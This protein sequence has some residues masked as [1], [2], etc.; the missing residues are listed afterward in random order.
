MRINANIPSLLSFK[1]FEATQSKLTESVKRLTTGLRVRSAAADAAGLAISEKM[2]AIIRGTDQAI[3]NAQDGQSMLRVAEG[4]LGEIH[5]IIQRMRELSLQAANDTLIAEDRTYIQLEIDELTAQI[6]DIANNTQFNKKKILNGDSAVL[7]S[8]ST[9]DIAVIVSG[10]LIWTD[11]FGEKASAAGN[12]KLTFNTV[13]SGSENVQKSNVMYL[14]H[15]THESA[16]IIDKL[17]GLARLNALNMAEG[18]WRLET[19][20]TPFGG[21]KFYEN[22]GS[23]TTEVEA[24][25]I[26]IAD[27]DASATPNIV[28]PGEYD[29]RVSDVVPMMADFK[30]ALDQGVVTGVEMSNRGA[31]SDFDAVFEIEANE[32]GTNAA[33]QVYRDDIAVGVTIDNA[34]L[35]AGVNIETSGTYANNVF[36]HF[37]VTETDARDVMMGDITVTESYVAAAGASIGVTLDYMSAANQSA[38]FETTYH[39][40]ANATITLTLGANSLIVNV[41]EK[42]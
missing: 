25:N 16:L 21:V 6:N 1:S 28:A 26:G 15:G 20:E 5:A 3:R 40:D 9:S 8:T 22:T 11:K 2:T 12:Y 42:N 33:T 29:I 18:D 24:E 35:S 30:D 38:T 36:T 34:N 14:K 19:R 10:N 37:A 41:A 32:T 23:G 39:A 27:F 4:A 31:T 17:S 13:Q 7:W